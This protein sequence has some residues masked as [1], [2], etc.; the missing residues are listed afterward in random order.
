MSTPS[1]SPTLV[2]MAAGMGSR[3]GGLKQ[4]DPV[5]PSGE[6]VIDYSVYDA[7]RAGFG[8]VVFIIRRD[9]EEDFR[10]VV[11]SHIRGRIPI[12]YAFQE[13]EDVPVGFQVPEVRTKPWGTGHAIFTCRNLVHETFGV[14]NA[15]DFYGAE[16]F[17][18]LAAF[19]RQTDP[20]ASAFALVAYILRNTLSGHG[21]VT[22]GVC[23]IRDGLLREVVE[24][25]KIEPDGDAARYLEYF[26]A[27]RGLTWWLVGFSLI[28]ANISTEQFVGMSGK[29]A[30]WLG[31]AI[32]S[33]EWMAAITLVVVAFVFLPTFLKSGIYTIPEFLE[34]RYNVAF[35]RNWGGLKPVAQLA[36]ATMYARPGGRQPAVS[37]NSLP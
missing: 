34:Y 32:A 26:L 15:D 17:R 8:K 37:R 4:I 9:I 13:L 2:I 3:Y 5:G 36:G 27:G 18:T 11:E 7:L 30:D 31:M 22:R 1:T 6:L 21:S 20:A 19:L 29:A 25:M 12:A 28:A 23:R 10:A 33:Y 14:I 24:R 35:A 16:S